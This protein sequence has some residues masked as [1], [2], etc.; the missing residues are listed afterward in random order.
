MN[1]SLEA[2]N[3]IVNELK[4]TNSATEKMKILSKYKNEPEVIKYFFY[5]YNPFY[6]YG[7]TSASMKKNSELS[8]LEFYKDIFEVLDLLRTRKLTGNK[9]IAA[10]NG[11][12][13]QNNK[14]IDL[15]YAIMDRN[16][17]IGM[18]EKQINKVFNNVIPT[19]DVALAATYEKERHE[20]YHLENYFI[21]RKLNGVRLVTTI[22]YDA[23]TDTTTI[24]SYSRK[25]KEFTTCGKINEEILEFYKASKFYKTNI[26]LDGEACVTDFD[27]KED[28]NKIVSEIKRK[29]HTIQSPKYIIFDLLTLD[30]FSGLT[31]SKNYGTRL[32]LLTKY[33]FGAL[34]KKAEY[35]SCV[36]SVPY[37]IENFDRLE[38]EFVISDKWEGFI[39]RADKAFKAGR[40]TDLLKYKLFKDAEYIVVDVENTVK[41]MLVNEK[42]VDTPCV[43]ALKIK[44]ENGSICGVGTGLT[45]AQR[46]EWYN[47]PELIIGK[48]IQVKY[49]ELTKNQD[50]SWSLQFPVLTHIFEE[51]NRDF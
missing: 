47:N 5:T 1:K 14:L 15:I 37:S 7:V 17:G 50:G 43:G 38:K 24:K 51:E 13:N 33:F 6:M 48:Q 36:F 20:K 29:N 9:A 25:G 8:E 11:F 35:L 34:D 12:A 22:E 30:E 46:I 32:K 45:D 10:I 42:M 49:K 16:L 3:E 27:G 4:E 2:F 44:L 23:V 19:F 21:Q 28:W 18:G 39:F 26:V 31:E 40:S 41:P